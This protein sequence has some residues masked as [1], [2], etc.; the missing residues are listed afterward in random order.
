MPSR[1]LVAVEA[2]Q[3]GGADRQLQQQKPHRLTHGHRAAR[4][5]AQPGARDLPVVI[6]VGDV[7][8]GAAGAA[9]DDGAEREQ[10]H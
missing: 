3:H 10:R 9:H 5:W 8:Q 2:E 1:M 4:Q 6:A 7:V